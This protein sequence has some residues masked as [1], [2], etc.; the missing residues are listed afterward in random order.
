MRGCSNLRGTEG[1][2]VGFKKCVC[3]CGQVDTGGAGHQGRNRSRLL[4]AARQA[5]SESR[6]KH[7]DVQELIQPVTAC[8]L[9]N[10]G[11]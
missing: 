7:P 10:E 8:N 9:G 1:V 4:S 3:G 6:F 5:L 2:Q 11:L